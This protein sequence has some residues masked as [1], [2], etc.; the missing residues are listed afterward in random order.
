MPE[1]DIIDGA[2]YMT[3]MPGDMDADEADASATWMTFKGL[4]EISSTR[5]SRPTH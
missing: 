1:L 5:A 3:E 4:P 2:D